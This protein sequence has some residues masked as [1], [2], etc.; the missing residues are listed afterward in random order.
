MTYADADDGQRESLSYK[1]QGSQALA[2][3]RSHLN[4]GRPPSGL[5]AGAHGKLSLSLSAAE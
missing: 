1:L 4:A 2:T 5:A 3:P